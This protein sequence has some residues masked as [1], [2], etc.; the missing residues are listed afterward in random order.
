[1]SQKLTILNALKEKG[2]MSLP[3]LM[4]L[5]TDNGCRIANLT[6]RISELRKE[7]HNIVNFEQWDKERSCFI[8]WYNLVT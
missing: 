3:D 2:E 7:H 5:R 4:D 8:S 1:M 6:G